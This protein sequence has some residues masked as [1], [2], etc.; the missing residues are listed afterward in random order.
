MS[1][2][3]TSR[4]RL[5]RKIDLLI[6]STAVIFAQ[7]AVGAM[8]DAD[9]STKQLDQ[10]SQMSLEE[11]GNIVITSVSKTPERVDDAPASIYVI[12]HDDIRRSGVTSL[13]EALRLAPNLQVAQVS[14]SSYTIT[15]RGFAG[16][17]NKLLVLIDGRSVYSPLFAGVFWDVQDVMMED[18][19][20]IEVISGPGGTLW[21]VNAVNG[22]INVI[23]RKASDTQG[24]LLSAGAGNLQNNSSLRY[25]GTLGDN[26]NYRLYAK[27]F[28][29]NHTDTAAGTP[30][31]DGWHQSQAGFRADWTLAGDQIRLEGNAY[32]GAEGQPAPGEISVTS[33]TIPLGPVLTSG[34]NISTEWDH[35]LDGGSSFK[36]QAYF[37][38]T[39][40]NVDPTFDDK[41]NIYDVQ[42]DFSFLPIAM[43]R[44]NWGAEYRYGM[45]QVTN[46]PYVAFLPAN[47]NQTWSSVYAQ[48]EITL[49]KNLTLT[50]GA[51]LEHNDYTGNEF[52]PNARLGWKLSADDFVWAAASRTVRAPSR[53][54]VDVFIP[55]TAPYELAGGPQV[56]SEV[57]RV[58]E[59]G[60][61]GQPLPNFSYSATLYKTYYDHLRT[62]TLA[63]SDTYIIFANGM[64]GETSGIEMW[65][66]YQV[67]P[68]WRLSAGLAT[69]RERVEL[70]SDEG[71]QFPEVNSGP[72]PATTW[73]LK[74]S[75]D[76][77]Y[78]TDLDIFVR[79]ATALTDPLVPT[80]SALGFRVGWN[81]SKNLE[82]SVTAQNLIGDGHGEF[83]DISTRSVIGKSVFFK[84]VSRF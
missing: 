37:D 83:S 71:V 48:D 78:Q 49:Q 62:A 7:H 31:D 16:D 46:S 44:F 67:T 21:G 55:G 68:I 2:V 33:L 43:H 26:G 3:P 54:D 77:P 65:G 60:Y 84:L 20:R 45:D 59:I 66:K 64:K 1:F 52:L 18:I 13:P 12:T 39:E 72:D 79:H 61:H 24:G 28:D 36:L 80:Y 10:F 70:Y 22:V 34:S 53:L 50:A 19:D 57:A 8:P 41:E 40:R 56:I 23:T 9:D 82:L 4:L 58:L 75:F 74:S 47:L 35:M 42:F 29:Y 15:A 17:A 6:V 76:L 73:S 51:R 38:R 30:V 5:P 11:L 69:L 81:V 25:G 27:T 63:P 14:A 32:R